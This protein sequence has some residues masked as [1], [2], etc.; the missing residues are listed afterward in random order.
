M[1]AT[2]MLPTE[3]RDRRSEASERA[4]ERLYRLCFVDLFALFLAPTILHRLSRPRAR[5]ELSVRTAHHASI[6]RDGARDPQRRW[7]V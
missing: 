1:K 3:R 6:R 5:A 7:L 4:S 2:F